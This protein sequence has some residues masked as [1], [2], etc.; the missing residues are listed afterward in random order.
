MPRLVRVQIRHLVAEA[1][2][3]NGL[4]DERGR[5]MI[6]EH[7][8]ALAVDTFAAVNVLLQ[9][10]ADPKAHCLGNPGLGLPKESHRL[11]AFR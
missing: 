11:K 10:I 1:A 2:R 4:S 6:E 7:G 3:R 5:G 8:D 9:M